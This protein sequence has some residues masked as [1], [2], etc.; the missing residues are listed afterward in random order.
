MFWRE[1]GVTADKHHELLHIYY[2]QQF[3]LPENLD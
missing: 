2:V 3:D 1:W